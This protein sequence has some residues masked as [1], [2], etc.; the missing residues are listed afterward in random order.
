M[1]QYP[2]GRSPDLRRDIR[3]CKHEQENQNGI[4]RDGDTIRRRILRPL[5]HH[6][7]GHDVAP[8]VGAPRSFS[9]ICLSRSFSIVLAQAEL[10]AATACCLSPMLDPSTAEPL[11]TAGCCLSADRSLPLSSTIL[12]R[13]L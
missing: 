5:I 8:A 2:T 10:L 12:A 3:P 11:S 7:I 4:D 9:A 1:L 6:P 13:L